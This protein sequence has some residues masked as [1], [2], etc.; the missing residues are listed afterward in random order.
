MAPVELFCHSRDLLFAHESG[1]TPNPGYHAGGLSRRAHARD[2]VA[3]A[4]VSSG[5][6]RNE[7]GEVSNQ[8]VH[9]YA[10]VAAQWMVFVPIVFRDPAVGG[11]GPSCGESRDEGRGKPLSPASLATGA[12]K[13]PD[14]LRYLDPCRSFPVAPGFDFYP[15]TRFPHYE[16]PV[17]PH[18]R[19]AA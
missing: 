1:A 7:A 19:P 6:A 9:N 3:S 11:R 14:S 12:T 15:C 8:R 10:T 17:P 2:A 16:L 5:A 4:G 13:I 18:L